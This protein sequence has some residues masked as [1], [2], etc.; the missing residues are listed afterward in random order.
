MKL[1]HTL[2]IG[3]VA[4]VITICSPPQTAV[5]IPPFKK[6]FEQKYAAVLEDQEVKK[7]FR[8]ANCNICHLK[9]KKKDV[10]NAYGSQLAELIEG[11]AKERIDIAKEAGDEQVKAVTEQLVA[12]LNEALVQAEEMEKEPGQKFG[13]I[14]KSGALPVPLAEQQADDGEATGGNG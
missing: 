10:R 7:T 13:E 3:L 8:K 2:T 4:S 6:A 12:E 9:G 11:G 5:A 14:I 1:N